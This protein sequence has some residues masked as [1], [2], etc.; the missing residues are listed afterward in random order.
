MR[1][2]RKEIDYTNPEKHTR[3]MLDEIERLRK[4]RDGLKKVIEKLEEWAIEHK[5]WTVGNLTLE[6]KQLKDKYLKVE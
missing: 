2:F 6:M 5:S 3:L 4:E 1:D